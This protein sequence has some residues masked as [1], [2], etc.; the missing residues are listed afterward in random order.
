MSDET[1]KLNNN[2][3]NN[4]KDDKG[5]KNNNEEEVD[6]RGCC[7]K[8]CDGYCGCIMCIGKGIYNCCLAIKNCCVSFHSKWWYPCKERCCNCCDSCDKDMHPYKDPHHNPY[9]YI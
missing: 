3:N 5:G 9:D 2:D 8:C 6:E 7:E 1:Q 4:N